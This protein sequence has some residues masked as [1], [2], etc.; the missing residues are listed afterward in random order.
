MQEVLHHWYRLRVVAHLHR[1]LHSRQTLAAL[2]VALAVQGVHHPVLLLDLEFVLLELDLIGLELVEERRLPGSE[3]ARLLLRLSHLGRNLL[4][5]DLDHRRLGVGLLLL[6]ADHCLSVLDFRRGLLLEGR[7]RHHKLL[8]VA[9]AHCLHGGGVDGDGVV[10]RRVLRLKLLQADDLH[11]A[12]RLRRGVR[13]RLRHQLGVVEGL[14][15]RL[16]VPLVGGLLVAL[17]EALG[18]L[19]EALDEEAKLLGLRGVHALVDRVQHLGRLIDHGQRRAHRRIGPALAD[20]LLRRA[21]EA[22]AGLGDV[23]HEVHQAHARLLVRER[24]DGLIDRQPARLDESAAAGRD[25]EDVGVLAA[26]GVGEQEAGEVG[27]HARVEHLAPRRRDC[28]RGVAEDV[29]EA[30]VV[31]AEARHERVLDERGSRL[32]QVVSLVVVA[33]D[34]QDLLR[35]DV[36]GHAVGDLEAGDLALVLV[37][38]VR[39]VQLAVALIDLAV[40]VLGPVG[41]LGDALLR[42]LFALRRV[43]VGLLRHRQ[44]AVLV[45][46]KDLEAA[47]GRGPHVGSVRD[48]LRVRQV[49]CGVADDQVI[50]IDGLADRAVAQ[51]A[52]VDL[53]EGRAA[54]AEHQQHAVGVGVIL[55][56][57]RGQVVVQ[58]ALERVGALV[59]AEV[60]VVVVVADLDRAVGRQQLAAGVGLKAQDGLKQERVADAAHALDR[61]TV[62]GPADVGHLDLEPEQLDALSA[63]LD[64]VAATFDIVLDAA[65]QVVGD[66]TKLRLVDVIDEVGKPPPL[67]L[68]GAALDGFAVEADRDRPVV[69]L[70]AQDVA[71][72]IGVSH[73]SALLDDHLGVIGGRRD[74]RGGQARQADVGVGKAGQRHGS[75]LRQKCGNLLVKLTE[76]ILR[77][78]GIRFGLD[79]IDAHI[80]V[81]LP[82]PDL[83]PELAEADGRGGADDV[84]D[85]VGGDHRCVLRGAVAA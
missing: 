8:R 23:G 15:E 76:A 52:L 51:R 29:K 34:G 42:A 33:D 66:N 79:G 56:R 13:I 50:G 72:V 27:E 48:A 55:R 43:E 69:V 37:L 49:G 22:H 73:V 82:A 40:A 25:A 60:G 26:T 81:R 44:V 71:R 35:G 78:E 64:P 46:A 18:V 36:N 77:R 17:P 3:P 83:D 16:L 9:P 5:L 85:G 58:V 74:V 65:H 47:H 10:H 57:G 59:L 7:G 41:R 54:E 84:N 1:Q 67:F 62:S 14:D 2:A 75:S 39:D 80:V 20:R 6:D 61:R 12:L 28:V 19:A 45:D 53:L 11:H 4:R 70:D 21:A 38:I 68:F 24:H 32:G 31:E 63:R 30:D